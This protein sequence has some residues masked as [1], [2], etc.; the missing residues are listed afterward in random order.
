MTGQLLT[1]VAFTLIGIALT[2]IVGRTSTF[3]LGLGSVGMVLYVAGVLHC[4]LAATLAALI[5]V[6]A[7]IVLIR[8]PHFVWPVKLDAP[9]VLTFLPFLLLLYVTS[10]NPLHDFDGRVFWVLKAKGIAS[11]RRIDGPFFKNQ[12]VYDPRNHY[13]LLVPLDGASLMIAARDD[14]DRHVRWIYPVALLALALHAR[15]WIGAWPAALLLWIPQFA[16]A[17]E[18]GVTSAYNDVI[19][20]AFAGCAFLELLEGESPLRFGLWLAFLTLT[21]SEGLAYALVLII[22]GAFIFRRCIASS[23]LPLAIAVS[24]LFV[25]RSRI[26]PGD[27]ENFIAALPHIVEKA[28][29]LGPALLRLAQHAIQFEVWGVFWVAT[30][31]AAVFVMVRGPRRKLILPSFVLCSMVGV[32]TAVYAVSSWNLHEL[33]DSSADRLLMHLIIPALYIVS[34]AVQPDGALA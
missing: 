24:T 13:P 14:D 34:A 12:S 5:T 29:R 16:I 32:Y 2:R 27:E 4:P 23:L 1:V 20:A 33:V 30:S 22:A 9:L 26:P 25:W 17:E 3:L 18:G 6:A 31:A 19:V 15:R 21:K 28:A 11:E 8:R 7:A 10:V